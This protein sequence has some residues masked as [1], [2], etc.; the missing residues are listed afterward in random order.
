MHLLPPLPLL[1][2]L[3]K[4]ISPA[5]IYTRI[6]LQAMRRLNNNLLVDSNKDMDLLHGVY[7]ESIPL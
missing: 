4:F 6:V 5:K 7:G 1:L 2:A 3:Q